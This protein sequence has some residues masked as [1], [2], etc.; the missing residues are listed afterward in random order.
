MTVR[1]RPKSA[2]DWARSAFSRTMK[3]LHLGRRHV[4]EHPPAHAQQ[5]RADPILA[6]LLPEHGVSRRLTGSQ[7]AA[8]LD[9]SVEL[10]DVVVLFPVE[11]AGADQ[12]VRRRPAPGA[13]APASARRSGGTSPGCTTRPGSRPDRRPGEPPPERDASPAATRRAVAT[14]ASWS[15]SSGLRP[16]RR[17]G[18]GDA[19]FQTRATRPP[20]TPS[21]RDWSPSTPSRIS[22]CSDDVVLA[23]R[24]AGPAPR[25]ATSRRSSRTRSALVRS[26]PKTDRPCAAAAETA[27]ERDRAALTGQCRPGE[28]EVPG[29]LGRRVVRCSPARTRRA[30]RD[31]ARRVDMP[32][33]GHDPSNHGREPAPA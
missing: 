10:A 32:S 21:G 3:A 27:G 16:K 15:P 30:G 25:A 23:P 19:G 31:G 26:C 4:G 5:L 28:H 14:T 20:P 1:R 17:V 6:S 7:E 8:V 22:M 29:R 12:V 33:P 13:A 18:R 9:L 24:D 2:R 11:V